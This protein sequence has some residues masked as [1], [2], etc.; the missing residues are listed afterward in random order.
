MIKK[1]SNN[2]MEKLKE[3]WLLVC[4]FCHFFSLQIATII[5]S[6]GDTKVRN[7]QL[8]RLC[9]LDFLS[10]K[11]LHTCMALYLYL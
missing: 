2:E 5:P 4:L 6:N 7:S 11:R 8:Q 1:P 3:E 10:G 9:S